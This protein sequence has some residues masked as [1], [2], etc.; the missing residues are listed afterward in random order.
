MGE[1][2]HRVTCE[3]IIYGH[4]LKVH[5]YLIRVVCYQ[6]LSAARNS[7][8]HDNLYQNG[9]EIGPDACNGKAEISPRLANHGVF[10]FWDGGFSLVHS[11]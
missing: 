2:K 1:N 10:S 9:I 11:L 4:T 8:E 3:E 6:E 7:T 5:T